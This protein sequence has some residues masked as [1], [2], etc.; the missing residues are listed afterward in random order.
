[1]PRGSNRGDEWR[2]VVPLRYQGKDAVSHDLELDATYEFTQSSGLLS[3][4]DVVKDERPD[5]FGVDVGE[6]GLVE[7]FC[8]AV[9][10][11]KGPTSMFNYEFLVPD[12]FIGARAPYEN[13]R[14]CDHWA[15]RKA[16]VYAVAWLAI[17][18]VV[19]VE[20]VMDK[21][22]GVLTEKE[23]HASRTAQM[24]SHFSKLAAASIVNTGLLAVLMNGNLNAFP[25][26]RRHAD[27]TTSSYGLLAGS[28]ED[29]GDSW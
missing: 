12:G 17:G 25:A 22:A 29:F 2:R 20:L 6:T 11:E 13:P 8:L 9:L 19:G 26:L 1:M 27:D 15:R 14:W 16:R 3:M 24:R 4:A 10:S 18:F 23:R 7:C 28:F 5:D 21:V